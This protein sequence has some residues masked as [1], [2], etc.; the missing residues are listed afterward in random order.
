MNESRDQM[1]I[2]VELERVEGFIFTLENN[3]NASCIPVFELLTCGTKIPQENKQTNKQKQL[4][5]KTEIHKSSA[6]TDK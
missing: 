1:K 4:N 3:S 2:Y 6:T 5:I